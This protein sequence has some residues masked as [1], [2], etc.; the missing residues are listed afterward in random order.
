[1]TISGSK[2]AK[3]S[4][5]TSKKKPQIRVIPCFPIFFLLTNYINSYDYMSL[6]NLRTYFFPLTEVEASFSDLLSTAINNFIPKIGFF[7]QVNHL[8]QP[9]SYPFPQKIL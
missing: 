5:K 1:M 7:W 6:C 4:Q 3:K 8:A 2:S 9:I